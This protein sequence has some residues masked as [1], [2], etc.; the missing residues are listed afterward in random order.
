MEVINLL[1]FLSSVQRLYTLEYASCDGDL[2]NFLDLMIEDEQFTSNIDLGLVFLSQK[3]YAQYTIVD[4]LGRILSLS[5]LLHAVCECYKKTSQ[6]N[7]KAIQ[8]IRKSYLFSG[9]NL[10]L[11]L[12]GRD[13]EIYSKIINGERLS[14]HEKSTPMFRLLHNFWTQIKEEKLQAAKIFTMLKKVNITVIDTGNVSSRNLYC[15]LNISRNFNQLALI[16]NYL[17][18]KKCL[19]LW[20]DLNQIFDSTRDLKLF[21]KDYFVTKFNYKKFE[22]SR[23]YENFV[24]Y[25][26]TMLSY[27]KPDVLSEKILHSA[28][29]YHDI[30]YVEFSSIDVKRAFI[31]IKKHGGEDTYAYI[32]EVYDDYIENNLTEETFIE[33]L[34]TISEYLKNRNINQNNVEFNELIKY[35]NAFITCK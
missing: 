18:E 4:G 17:E 12:G 2:L 19:K 34:N 6:K 10:K 15:K 29:L 20:E 5:L 32:L 22:E 28:K 26:D 31:Q 8:T 11:Q 25:F 14:G 30:L 13:S 7:E 27:L 16:K 1:D 23:L 3:G 33:I 9:S 24:N 21:F 35:L